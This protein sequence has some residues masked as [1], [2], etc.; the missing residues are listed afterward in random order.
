MACQKMVAFGSG[1]ERSTLCRSLIN[2]LTGGRPPP[3]SW[4]GSGLRSR[5]PWSGP[6][7]NPIRLAL[8]ASRLTQRPEPGE[9]GVAPRAPRAQHDPVTM[10][11]P[12]H[13]V[14][15]V[16]A[17]VHTLMM[18]QHDSRCRYFSRPLR[19]AFHNRPSRPH[20]RLCVGPVLSGAGRP[21]GRLLARIEC[22]TLV[23][24]KMSAL[25]GSLVQRQQ[26]SVRRQAEG[27]LI[28]RMK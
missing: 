10:C 19:V 3:V 17:E 25:S 16:M 9:C 2:Q 24:R 4:A 1:S 26:L 20:P 13:A 5:R 22:S 28:Y 23:L 12:G 15:A 27:P 6:L 21:G 11:C 8:D 7:I 14:Y 18:N